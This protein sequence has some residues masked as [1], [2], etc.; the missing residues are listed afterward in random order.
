MEPYPETVSYFPVSPR[1]FIALSVLTFG[2]YEIYWFYKNW[3]FV[4]TRDI[5][6]IRPWARALFA[7]LWYPAFLQSFSKSLQYGPIT[8]GGLV[9]PA[10]IYFL[11]TASVRLPDPFW[12]ISLFSFVPLLP[13]VRRI[14]SAN[15]EVSGP[16]AQ[17]SRCMLRHSVLTLLSAPAIAFVV[18]SSIGLIP[19]TQVT[20]GW[21]LWGPSRNFL[22]RS[23]IIAPDER[24]FY[25]YSEGFSSF[26]IDGNILTGKRVIS[27]WADEET[28]ELFV[29]SASFS[30]IRD[31]EVKQGSWLEP[32]VLTVVR[33]DGSEFVLILSAEEGRDQLFLRRLEQLLQ[34]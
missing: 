10:A 7:P 9:A 29:E 6:S 22:E 19:S 11:L 4:R 33:Q 24:V 28:G 1:K 27:Y 31:T 21:M 15:R 26:A 8:P 34:L 13:A 12:L 32:T 3:V 5:S 16:Y 14:N 17:N 18:A 25:F 20:P 30:E 23:A 2:L